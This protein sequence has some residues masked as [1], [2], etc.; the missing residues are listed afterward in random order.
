MAKTWAQI[1][2]EDGAFLSEGKVE[3]GLVPSGKALSHSGNGTS[4]QL[5][6]LG[7]V[8]WRQ[9]VTPNPQ[10]ARWKTAKEMG[11]VALLILATWLIFKDN[12]QTCPRSATSTDM[13]F[14]TKPGLQL[15]HKEGILLPSSAPP[16]PDW[17]SEREK[18]RASE[19]TSHVCVRPN[20]QCVISAGGTCSHFPEGRRRNRQQTKTCCAQIVSVLVICRG[21][22]AQ[23]VF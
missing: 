3:G 8:A 16:P 5:E 22:L 20:S 10:C 4:V 19:P 13:K 12:E 14:E 17:V 21:V 23:I 2:W 9:D 1:Q 11:I 7:R 18:E 6:P 15:Q